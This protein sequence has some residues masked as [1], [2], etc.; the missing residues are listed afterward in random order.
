[1]EESNIVDSIE[2]KGAGPFNSWIR[3]LKA[4]GTDHGKAFPAHPALEDRV[5]RP[6]GQKT[7]ESTAGSEYSGSGRKVITTGEGS[8]APL[9]L[10]RCGD[11]GQTPLQLDLE[12]EQPPEI[13]MGEPLEIDIADAFGIVPVSKD[14]GSTTRREGGSGVPPTVGRNGGQKSLRPESNP[15]I[16]LGEPLEIDMVDAFGAEAVRDSEPPTKREGRGVPPTVGKNDG[17]EPLR[18]GPPA[19]VD[20]R[21]C[22]VRE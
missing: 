21:Y 2:K 16:T 4:A 6:S 10:W 7:R 11:D 13:T 22:F 12:P 18:P 20:G 3:M 17:K 15:E 9:A 5:G 8:G 19:W 14:S 1:L